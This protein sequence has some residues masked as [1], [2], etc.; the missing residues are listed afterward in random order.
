MDNDS[1]QA[2]VFSE[3]PVKNPSKRRGG[4]CLLYTFLV[5]VGLSI[6]LWVGF[7]LGGFGREVLFG[8]SGEPTPADSFGPNQ[9][10]FLV[11]GVDRISPGARLYGTWFVTYLPGKPFVKLV[12]LFPASPGTSSGKGQVLLEAFS[13][14]KEI[15]QDFIHA[16]EA[17]YNLQWDGYVL[18]DQFGMIAII[19]FLG[20][21]DLG[22]GLVDGVLAIRDLPSP[23][24]NSTAA[25]ESQAAL[26]EA[27]CRRISPEAPPQEVGPIQELIPEFLLTNLD[28]VKAETDWLRL[29]TSP[30]GIQCE[31]PT[32]AV[33][34]P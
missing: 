11:I 15:S 14:D 19:D 1:Y 3:E 7:S 27:L 30:A 20:G 24:E 31:F 21:V 17:Q 9:D 8:D 2:N 23:G 12:P 5:V 10:A 22:D 13:F 18:L 26:L 29:V 33:A 6:G 4:R 16:I 32:M 25:L 34:G 28:Q